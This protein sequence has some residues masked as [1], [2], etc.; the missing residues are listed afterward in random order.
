MYKNTLIFVVM[1]FCSYVQS[2]VVVKYNNQYIPMYIY[3][4]MYTHYVY[5]TNLNSVAIMDLISMYKY[6]YWIHTYKWNYRLKS[7]CSWN[8]HRYYTIALQLNYFCTR[9]RI[10]KNCHISG[11]DVYM[12]FVVIIT[13]ILHSQLS[14]SC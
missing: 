5:T 14:F 4:C 10:H 9:T 2:I 12:I 6:V 1:Q 13:C 7:L 11:Y 3:T 8:I